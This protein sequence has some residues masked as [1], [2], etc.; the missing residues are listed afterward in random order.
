M[1]HLQQFPKTISALMVLL[2]IPWGQEL[3]TTTEAHRDEPPLIVY[4]QTKLNVDN[5]VFGHKNLISINPNG[6]KL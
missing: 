1:K 3:M 4:L 6:K 5:T 2:A